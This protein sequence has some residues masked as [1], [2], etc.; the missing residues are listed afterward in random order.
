MLQPFNNSICSNHLIIIICA[1]DCITISWIYYYPLPLA[2]ALKRDVRITLKS[3]PPQKKNQPT[4]QTSTKNNNKQRNKQRRIFHDIKV[5]SVLSP[6]N[7]IC[8][9][10]HRLYDY[11]NPCTILSRHFITFDFFKVCSPSF[12]VK[13][14]IK[15][16]QN[17]CSLLMFWF[18]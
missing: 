10:L 2:S 11:T 18:E 8:N 3:P 7:S 1:Q 5:G 14:S 16:S 13:Y 6:A 15:S 12:T 17:L 9:V 4:K